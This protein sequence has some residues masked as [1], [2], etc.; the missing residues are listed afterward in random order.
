MPGSLMA[1][2]E[3]GRIVEVVIVIDHIR[4]VDLET[5]S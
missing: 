3:Y 4:E 5:T 2:H 1:V